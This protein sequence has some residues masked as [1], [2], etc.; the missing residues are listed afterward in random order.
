VA[1]QILCRLVLAV[2]LGVQC[3]VGVQRSRSS[4]TDGS[5]RVCAHVPVVTGPCERTAYMSG[6]TAADKKAFEASCGVEWA[7]LAG[8]CVHDYHAPC[9]KLS[10][11]WRSSV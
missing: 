6:A 8:G 3:A 10:G 2:W 7:A 4:L 5:S 1:H 11:G 9:H